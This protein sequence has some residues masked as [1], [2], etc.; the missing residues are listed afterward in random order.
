MG[1]IKNLK[2]KPTK[3][4]TLIVERKCAKQCALEVKETT[5]EVQSQAM[6]AK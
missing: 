1:N 4:E 6:E 5:K 3:K 2:L